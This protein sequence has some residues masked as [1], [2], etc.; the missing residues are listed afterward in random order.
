MDDREM[1][2]AL[3]FMRVFAGVCLFLAP[4]RSGRA[5]TGGGGD[6]VTANLALR[7]M[8]ARDVALGVGTLVALERGTP[9]RGWIE[10]GVL[11]DSADAVGTVMRWRSLGNVRAL[12][13]LSAELG[14]ALFGSRLAQTVDQ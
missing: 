6:E 10:A 2:K 1:A 4:G 11:S 9:V 14:A 8:G 7:G 3:G 5:W 12:F 13:W